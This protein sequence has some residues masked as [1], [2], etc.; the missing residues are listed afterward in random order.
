M[1]Q[2]T[3]K[4]RIRRSVPTVLLATA[5]PGKVR[6]LRALLRGVPI[7]LIS[8]G[9]ARLPCGGQ[10]GPALPQLPL[11]RALGPARPA[12]PPSRLVGRAQSQAGSLSASLRTGTGKA[13]RPSSPK[14]LCSARLRNESRPETGATYEDN[15]RSKALTA[16]RATGLPA[17]AE[18]S[19][20]EV[21]ALGRPALGGWPGVKS[22]RFMG[23]KATS[24]DRNRRILELLSGVPMKARTARFRSFAALA[25]P[26]GRVEVAEGTCEGRIAESPGGRRGFGY[27]PIFIPRGFRRT[28][29]QLSL[30]E[31]N[32]ISHRGKAVRALIRR[33]SCLLRDLSASGE[34]PPD[35]RSLWEG[36]ALPRGEA[37]PL[38]VSPCLARATPPS[39]CLP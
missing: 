9:Q 12:S 11:G 36:V 24:K 27:D 15:A 22:N 32:R 13:G 33:A 35:D 18:D 25:M 1:R 4:P 10:A 20:I 7:R 3:R 29:A 31:K 6:E 26:D 38:R 30:A 28:M 14:L 34:T 2:G 37:E 16:A 39:P 5:N 19:G 17:I 8:L 23:P 21:D